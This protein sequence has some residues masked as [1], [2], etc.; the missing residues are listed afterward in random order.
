V[1]WVEIKRLI[2]GTLRC[3]GLVFAC[4]VGYKHY[5]RYGEWSSHS[6]G[7]V[8]CKPFGYE[9]LCAHGSVLEF[10]ET[11]AALGVPALRF[12]YLCT[13]DSGEPAWSP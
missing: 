11:A 4:L 10:A 9:A 12:D 13:G 2:T 7:V 5:R 3:C 6:V 8:V 1:Y